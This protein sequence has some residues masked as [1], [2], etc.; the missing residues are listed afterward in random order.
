M[1]VH[2]L[3]KAGGSLEI[4][5]LLYFRGPLH[6]TDFSAKQK[7]GFETV[8]RTLNVLCRLGLVS[9]LPQDRFPYG[10]VCRLTP[11]G[12]ELVESPAVKWPSLFWQ[13]TSERSLTPS[14]S[15]YPI[16][17]ESLRTPDQS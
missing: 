10:Q 1:T 6:K 8:Y 7:L 17:M 16:H 13:W 5:L 12:K 2:Q 15:E 3:M 4:L 14:V 11:R 9:I